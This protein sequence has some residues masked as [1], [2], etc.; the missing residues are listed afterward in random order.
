MLPCFHQRRCH[1]CKSP[2]RGRVIVCPVCGATLSAP[3]VSEHCPSCGARYAP[4]D[5][6]CLIC[7]APRVSLTSRRRV[8]W[9]PIVAIAGFVALVG[10]GGWQIGRLRPTPAVGGLVGAVEKVASQA[11]ALLEVPSPSGTP[12]PA[13]SVTPTRA[14]TR[15]PTAT[16]TVLPSATAAPTHI[17]PTPT[18]VISET[19]A[20]PAGNTPAALSEAPSATPTLRVHVVAKG[21]VLGRIAARYD[22]TVAEIAAL[23]GISEDSILQLGQELLIPPA[24]G[25]EQALALAPTLAPTPTFAPTEWPTPTLAPTET[26]TPLGWGL[27]S[28]AGLSAIEA[29]RKGATMTPTATLTPTPR[30]HTVAKGDTLGRIALLYDV[31]PARIAEANGIT[32]ETRLQIGQ[33]LRIPAEGEEGVPIPE[34]TPTSNRTPLPTPTATATPVSITYT[35]AKGDTLGSIAVRYGVSTAE[36]AKANGITE[37]TL[38]QIGQV[39]TIPSTSVP[40]TSTLALTATPAFTPTET[41]TA[42][43]TPSPSPTL[44]LLPTPAFRYRAPTLLWPTNGSSLQGATVLPL[45]NWTSVGILAEDEWYRLRVWGQGERETPTAFYTKATSYRLTERVYPQ[46]RR[47]RQIF[48]DVTVVRLAADGTL[49]IPQSPPSEEHVFTWR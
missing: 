2:V 33:V 11:Q 46:G 23:N 6:V 14:V 7:G 19:P 20:L 35:V 17:L 26:P 1:V 10:L 25:G 22:V 36:I 44:V 24:R 28:V 27:A 4:E 39:L 45:L 3:K 38:L 15:R 8:R 49:E 32:L 21:D 13:A 40:L 48:W 5:T 18:L 37:R 29:E 16:R 47:S 34:A 42:T 9:W 31:S 41:P 12:L 43:P 30:V